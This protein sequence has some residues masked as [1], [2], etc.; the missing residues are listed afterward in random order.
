MSALREFAATPL[1]GVAVTIALYAAA[2]RCSERFRW[3]HPLFVTAGGVILLLLAAD[4]PYE[5]YAAGG[6]MIV[7]FLGPA[8]IALAVPLYKRRQAIMNQLGRI[9]GSI[10]VGSA[11]GIASCWML[12]TLFHGSGDVLLASLPKSAT[13]GISVELVRFLDGPP[14]LTAVFT[15]LTGLIG[16]MFGPALLRL[17]RLDG[18]L[19]LGLAIGTASHGIGT[20]RLLQHSEEAGSYSGLAMGIAGVVI[21][22]LMAPAAW[23]L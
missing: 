22:L 4:I 10:T 13:A 17:C 21:S 3:L 16:S 2:L 12:V 11:A 15:V 20:S 8:T 6:D 9:I 7:F 1:F 23:L 5:A 14:E 18:A 19:P